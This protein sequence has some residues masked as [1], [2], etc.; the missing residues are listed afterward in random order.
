[1]PLRALRDAGARIALGADDPLLFGSRL[2]DQYAFARE[3]HGFSDE[4]LAE[5]ARHSIRGSRAPDGVRRALLSGVDDWLARP[6]G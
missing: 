3:A 6:P 4:Q 2:T 1:M 5:L